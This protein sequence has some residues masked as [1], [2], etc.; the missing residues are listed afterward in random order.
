MNKCKIYF[1][2]PLFEGNNG[3][4]IS[5]YSKSTPFFMARQSSLI[6]N[7][8]FKMRHYEAS[9]LTLQGSTIDATVA[10]FKVVQSSKVV[11]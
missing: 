9:Y 6:F 5:L 10:R 8:E 11:C 3:I 7:I 4:I 1:A 2:F